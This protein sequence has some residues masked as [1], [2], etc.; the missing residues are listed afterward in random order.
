[1][2]SYEWDRVPQP[3]RTIPYRQMVAYWAGYYHVG[4]QYGLPP[5]RVADTLAAIVMSESWF[6]H[7][8][9]AVNRDGT[10]DIGLAGASD[11]VRERLRQLHTLGI[12]D[13]EIGDNDYYNP[14][15]ATRFVAIRRP[16]GKEEVI[17]ARR[18]PRPSA[19]L[20]SGWR[21]CS[22]SVFHAWPFE[23]IVVRHVSLQPAARGVLRIPGDELV[24]PVV[25]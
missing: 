22:G 17:G 1:M 15:P 7:R 12:V 11:F 8:G 23:V 24:V 16:A 14:W 6:D 19:A 20:P 10:R 4:R 18:H 3:M 2:D 9:L 25:D 21:V 13:V 5:G